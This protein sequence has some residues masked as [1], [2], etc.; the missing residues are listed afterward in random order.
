MFTSMIMAHHAST[1]GTNQSDRVLGI[2]DGGNSGVSQKIADKIRSSPHLME[3][4]CW[5]QKDFHTRADKHF[6]NLRH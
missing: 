2:K 1:V 5:E 4:Y 6:D 3:T